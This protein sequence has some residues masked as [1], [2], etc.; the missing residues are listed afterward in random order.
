MKNGMRPGRLRVGGVFGSDTLCAA[1]MHVLVKLAGVCDVSFFEPDDV[2]VL[3]IVL[4]DFELLALVE[5]IVELAAVDFE[6]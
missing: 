2:D 3:L 5:E 1:V 4:P 6:E